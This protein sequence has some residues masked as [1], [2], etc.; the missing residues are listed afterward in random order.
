MPIRSGFPFFVLKIASLTVT[1]NLV[2][3]KKVFYSRTS[4][5]DQSDQRQLQNLSG[6]DYVLSDK[7]S[8]IVP[9]FERPKG[10]QIQTLIDANQLGELHIH[11]I[12][13]LGRSLVDVMRVWTDL[14]EKGITIVCR[15]P[16]LRN[17][18]E[19]GKVDKFSQLMMGILST[20]SDFERSLIKERQLEGIRIFKEK[21]GYTGRKI[22]STVSSEV[23]LKKP[24]SIRVKEYL[25]KGYKIREIASIVKCSPS[26]VVKV[27]KLICNT[28]NPL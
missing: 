12:D 9:L 20:M 3:M 10:K 15:N 21:Q 26:T 5:V 25:S 6:F 7:I 1:Y 27:K 23:F 11:S 18:T 4:T 17:L 28:E 14:T 22:G 13:R 24:S 16:S 8:G 19:D 2:Q